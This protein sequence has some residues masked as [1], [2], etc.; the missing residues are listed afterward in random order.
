MVQ[1][2]DQIVSNQT[3]DDPTSKSNDSLTNSTNNTTDEIPKE[4]V[5]EYN[6]FFCIEDQT[7]IAVDLIT[8]PN[9]FT[10][11][12]IMGLAPNKNKNNIV[13]TLY[14]QGQI[15]KEIVTLNLEAR[16]HVITFGS[17][18]LDGI[19]LSNEDENAQVRFFS[20]V[21]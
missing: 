18:N 14:N 15:D 4:P 13:R 2:D 1:A 9:S 8:P 12:G 16:G 19:I 6:Y 20:N 17:V 3:I 10:E 5:I 7:F 21:G 11:N